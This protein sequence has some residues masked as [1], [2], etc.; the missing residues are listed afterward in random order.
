MSDS[1]ISDKREI[2]RALKRRL[3]AREIQAALLGVGADPIINIEI[4][5]IKQKI[6]TIESE[7]NALTK[8]F[9]NQR[10]PWQLDPNKPQQALSI[11]ISEPMN[12]TTLD[13][14]I[15]TARFQAHYE[16]YTI[17]TLSQLV[18]INFRHHDFTS[19]DSYSIVNLNKLLG[20]FYHSH[21]IN[22]NSIINCVWANIDEAIYYVL[23]LMSGNIILSHRNNFHHFPRGKGAAFH[24]NDYIRT[25]APA[26]P[27]CVAVGYMNRDIILGYG[28]GTVYL[29]NKDGY[30]F[31][32]HKSRISC[33]DA[34]FESIF[35]TGTED[36][37]IGIWSRWARELQR[38]IKTDEAVHSISVSKPFGNRLFATG[39][40]NGRINIWSFD[41][42]LV[43]SIQPKF[44]NSPI[45]SISFCTSP[46]NNYL[47]VSKDN[48]IYV[49]DYL[50]GE[51]M[52]SIFG[53]TVNITTLH[54]EDLDKYHK[55]GLSHNYDH[56]ILL[57]AGYEDGNV[58]SWEIENI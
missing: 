47:A 11:K 13:G 1:E 32:E 18:E 39:H 48:L 22:D 49:Y 51:H 29:W 17:A 24:A 7:I 44:T 9:I 28:D 14:S 30:K 20:E 45:T 3:Q 55:Y 33:I 38:I 12:V 41:G 54:I 31:K 27:T 37:E 19:S 6:G 35:V 8:Q 26:N 56:N 58:Y 57:T 46:N 15:Q 2:L 10:Y 40:S 21:N 25:G 53:P 43:R 16:Y 5:D 4:N 34:S 36:G 42:R 50:T 23:V 52:C